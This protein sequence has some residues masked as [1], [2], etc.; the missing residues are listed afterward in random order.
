M[1]L[2]ICGAQNSH[3]LETENCSYRTWVRRGEWVEFRLMKM[4]EALEMVRMV[5]QYECP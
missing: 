1:T 5:A 2:L 3:I 4:K